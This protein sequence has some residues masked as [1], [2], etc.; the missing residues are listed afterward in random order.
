VQFGYRKAKRYSFMRI[1]EPLPVT[2]SLKKYYKTSNDPI[3]S[4]EII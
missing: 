1:P 2:L 3:E 4:V